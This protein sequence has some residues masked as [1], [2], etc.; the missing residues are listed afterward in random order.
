M[1]FSFI[2]LIYFF[3]PET[4]GL[5]LEAL[6]NVFDHPGIT[7]G[8]LSKQHRKA[9]LEMSK[10]ESNM[11]NISAVK[12]DKQEVETVDSEWKETSHA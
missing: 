9:M 7:R 1:N 2:P 11:A 12:L 10:P 8:V 6:D 3:F 5:S 4:A